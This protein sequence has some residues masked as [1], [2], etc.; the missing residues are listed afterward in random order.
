MLI[1]FIFLL[2]IFIELFSLVYSSP[3]SFTCYNQTNIDSKPSPIYIN[4]TSHDILVSF[5]INCTSDNTISYANVSISIENTRSIE[6]KNPLPLDLLRFNTSSKYLTFNL[7]IH[8]TLVG[9]SK[10]LLQAEYLNETQNLFNYTN[11]LRIEFAVK[12]KT[13]VLDT[14]FTVAVILLVCIGTFLIGCRLILRNLYVNIR[15]PIPILI[16][17]FSQFLCL[18]LVRKQNHVLNLSLI[19]HFIIFLV[20][21]WFSKTCKIGLIDINWFVI[22]RC[23]TWWWCIEY[24]YSYV[25]W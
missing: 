24:V 11:D 15:K 5:L 20:S 1:K 13:T 8:G 12:R 23:S 4:D 22:N 16:G 25:W 17:L 2:I 10:L 3:C 21:L 7:I 18:P 6:I 14:I 19:F 9:Y